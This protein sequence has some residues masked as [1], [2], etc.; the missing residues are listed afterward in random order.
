MIIINPSI[1]NINSKM[2]LIMRLRVTIGTIGIKD[3]QSNHPSR[4]DTLQAFF[5]KN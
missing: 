3:Y 1:P 2:V 5:D 4:L